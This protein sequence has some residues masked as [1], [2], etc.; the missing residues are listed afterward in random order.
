M[1]NL[2]NYTFES[3]VREMRVG[4]NEYNELVYPIAKVVTKL[5]SPTRKRKVNARKRP[6][7]KLKLEKEIE[8]LRGELSILSELE[9]GIN[10]KGKMCRELKKKYK[11]NEE[12]ITRVKETLKQ[13][14]HF[15]A[16]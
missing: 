16:Q 5:C 3:I 6:S 9:R 11:F 4:M 13:R 15:K 12:N 1:T 10:V 8:H 14:M 2:G 7:W